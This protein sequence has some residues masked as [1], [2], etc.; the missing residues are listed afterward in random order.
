MDI[1][2]GYR[3]YIRELRRGPS[4]PVPRVFSSLSAEIKLWDQ[5]QLDFLYSFIF[6]WSV[7]MREVAGRWSGVTEAAIEVADP[8]PI[9]LYAPLW[10]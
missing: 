7:M 8:T 9:R 6:N 10:P 2:P 1:A 5:F 4:P 3:A